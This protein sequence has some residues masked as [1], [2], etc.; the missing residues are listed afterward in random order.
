MWSMELTIQL[1][2]ESGSLMDENF[3]PVCHLLE[4]HRCT[5]FYDLK[6]GLEH[7]KAEVEKNDQAPIQF[8]RDNLDAFLQCYDTLSDI[9]RNF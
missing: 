5:C 3:D 4:K 8:M 6:V 9:L 1:P 7:L 2:T